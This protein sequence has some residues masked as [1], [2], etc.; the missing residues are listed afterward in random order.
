MQIND[1]ITDAVDILW[2]ALI[3]VAAYFLYEL[4]ADPES[5]IAQGACNTLGVGCAPGVVPDS[6]L[7]A[8][9]WKAGWWWGSASSAVSDAASKVETTAGSVASGTRG[10]I[11]IVGSVVTGGPG[12]PT[13]PAA[14]GL[15][16]GYDPATG[17]IDGS[18]S[19]ASS[20]F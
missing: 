6:G 3:G 1:P 13:A 4:Y 9:A 7:G 12:T 10:A 5:S 2:L 11:D 19:G 14:P 17:T 15:P 20:T 8:L 16:A 18:P